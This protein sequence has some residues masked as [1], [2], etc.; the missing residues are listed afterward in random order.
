MSTVTENYALRPLGVGAPSTQD[1]QGNPEMGK[2]AFLKLMMTQMANQDPTAPQ[3]S[4]QMATQLAQF[5]TLEAMQQTNAKLGALLMAQAAGNQT[6]MANLIGKDIKIN[7]SELDHQS[8]DAENM[9]ILLEGP[10]KEVTVTIKDASGNAVRTLHL[11]T[12]GKGSFDVEWDGL[13]ENGEP[14]YSM[15]SI[16]ECANDWVSQG[17]AL[18][19]GIVK[20][21]QAYYSS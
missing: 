1:T 10:A 8:G 9:S 21:Y 3:D 14:M 4:Q 2:D 5:S 12:Q 18:P 20:Y 13:D 16:T 6:A 7:S 15:K 17:H 11:G 19:H